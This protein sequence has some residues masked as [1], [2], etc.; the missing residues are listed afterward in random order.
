MLCAKTMPVAMQEKN[1]QKLNM[2]CFHVAYNLAG[3]T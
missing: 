3:E 1:E 2:C